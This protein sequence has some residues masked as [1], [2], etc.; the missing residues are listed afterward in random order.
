MS[1]VFPVTSPTENRSSNDLMLADKLQQL[2][3][4]YHWALAEGPLLQAISRN[5][6]M[7][8]GARGRLL[9]GVVKVSQHLGLAWPLLSLVGLV[10]L[11]RLLLRQ[12]IAMRKGGSHHDHYPAR[13]FVGFGAGKEEELFV[14]YCETQADRVGRLDQVNVGSF[15][16]WHGVDIVSGLRSLVRAL[17]VAKMALAALPPECAP[18]RADFFTYVGMRAGYFAYMRAWFE[19][20]K[21]KTGARVDEIAFLTGYIPAFAAVEVGLPTCYLQH[22]MIRHSTLLPAF[23][24]VEA[25]TASDAAFIRRRLPKARVTTHARSRQALVPSQ[26]AREIL[27]ASIYYPDPEY[28]SRIKPFVCWANDMKVP[29]RVRP[30]PCED[31]TFWPGYERAGQVAID[32]NDDDFFHA[33]ARLQPRLVVSWFSTAMD[34][35]L[36]CGVIPISVCADDD[37]HVADMVYPLFQRCLRW[38]QDA[39]S[40]A[41]LLDDDEYYASVSSRL[42]E[43]L[44]EVG[45]AELWCEGPP[46]TGVC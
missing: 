41:R 33:I 34:D 25:L 20:L 11:L 23:M 36:R 31:G 17:A 46:T 42:R 38:P 39:D 5:E 13:F 16:V 37:P 3:A 10:E 30:H 19:I 27:V 6:P 32:E 14:R 24:R 4:Q 21:T 26:M 22:G 40:I 44:S 35:A 28:I 9:G 18:W 43:G 8:R 15:S 7:V 2:P 29:I 12:R 1:A 45:A